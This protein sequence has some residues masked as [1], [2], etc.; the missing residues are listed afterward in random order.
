MQT[1]ANIALVKPLFWWVFYSFLLMG[2]VQCTS[3]NEKQSESTSKIGSISNEQKLNNEVKKI[4]H[5]FC[6]HLAAKNYGKL[7]IFADK[8]TQ[9]FLLELKNTDDRFLNNIN[10]KQVDTCTVSEKEAFCM[11]LFESNFEDVLTPVHLIHYTSGWL[12]HLNWNYEN[13]NPFLINTSVEKRTNAPT[14]LSPLTDS[15]ALRDLSNALNYSLALIHF[16]EVVV[17]YMEKE[18]LRTNPILPPRASRIPLTELIEQGKISEQTEFQTA[19]TYSSFGYGARH[20]FTSNK[21]LEGINFTF[22]LSNKEEL[23]SYFQEVAVL[24]TQRY[25][26]PYNIHQ[27]S[28]EQL[29]QFQ[30]LKWFVKGY[31]EELILTSENSNLELTLL[32]VKKF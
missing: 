2:Y 12:I 22:S 18:R 25:G 20:I 3:K 17:N 30:Q 9:Q 1:M 28:L 27:A 4:A 19:I 24:L 21:T 7:S 15:L 14:N 13:P 8:T 29:Y 31:N 16:P 5:G 11:C 26:K 6:T 23:L 10:F 32:S